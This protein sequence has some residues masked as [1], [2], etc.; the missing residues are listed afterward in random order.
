MTIEKKV[1]LLGIY[2]KENSE[3]IKDV[4]IKL[5]ETGMFTFKEAKKLFKEL[6][7]DNLVQDNGLTLAG[8]EEAKIIEQEF[9]L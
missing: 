9:K 4:L 8:I 5:E 3:T 1:L 6:K 7:E 2:T